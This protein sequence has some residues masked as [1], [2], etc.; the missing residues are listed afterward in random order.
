M[1]T[2]SWM[3][4]GLAILVGLVVIVDVWQHRSERERP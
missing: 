1:V 2:S 3:I 4:L